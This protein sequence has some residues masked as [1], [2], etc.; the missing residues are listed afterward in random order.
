MLTYQLKILEGWD[1][2]NAAAI[3]HKQLRLTEQQK[4][5]ETE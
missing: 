5:K 4:K 3:H 1:N 2:L